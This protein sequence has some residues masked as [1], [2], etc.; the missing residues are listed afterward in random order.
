MSL[1]VSPLQLQAHLEF[2]IEATKVT[3]PPPPPHS[4]RRH[5][6]LLHEFK[7]CQRAAAALLSRR[8]DLINGFDKSDAT[9]AYQW[10]P[11]FIVPPLRPLSFLK[12]SQQGPSARR[13]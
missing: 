4:K 5:E 10:A 11:H 3:P 2:V 1:H 9:S 8:E 13:N 12:R 6:R 7:N